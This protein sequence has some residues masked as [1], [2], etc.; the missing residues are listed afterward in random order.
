MRKILKKDVCDYPLPNKRPEVR[1]YL[2]LSIISN[3]SVPDLPIYKR[4]IV[5]TR[6]IISE[7]SKI[8]KALVLHK[9]LMINPNMIG[10]CTV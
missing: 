7:F 5:D 2:S 8:V 6:V 4:T 9:K 3:L 10:L 1:N